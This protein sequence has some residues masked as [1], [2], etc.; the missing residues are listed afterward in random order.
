MFHTKRTFDFEYPL[1]EAD[2]CLIGIPFSSTEIGQDV[3]YGPLFIREAIKNLTGHNP[4]A[5]KNI[6]TEK[7]FHDAGDVEIVPGSWKLTEKA[8]TDAIEEMFGEN[9]SVFPVFLGGEHLITLAC[10]K[11]ISEHIG[12]RVSIADF[13][14]HRDLLS[15][16]LGEKH[17][18]ITWAYHALKTGKF[19]I[20]QF[21]CRAFSPE[22]E[23]NM[24]FG[25]F[26][27]IKRPDMP[28]YISV[29]LDVFDPSIAPEVGTQQAG[30]ITFEEFKK[31]IKK[32]K[33][34]KIIG[35]D[36]VE[37]ASREVESRTA[38]IAAEVIRSVLELI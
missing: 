3:K 34:A 11:A 10:A 17:S 22:E 29:D 7:K 13:D 32:L 6:F 16:W 15:E 36:V 27:G 23:K 20:M 4:S 28:V 35:M 25:A 21:G 12:E 31:E 24:K 30:G 19:E 9:K 38:H 14:A 33:G 26:D 5:G 8:I 1:K 18:H 2:V 37:C